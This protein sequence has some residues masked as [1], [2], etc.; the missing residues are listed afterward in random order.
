M[1]T[2]E[3]LHAGDPENRALWERFMPHCLEALTAVYERLGVRFDVQLGESFYDPMLA[4]IISWA[5][6]RAE[7]ASALANAVARAKI[8]GL[9]TNRDLL[10]RV[11]R[12]PAFLAGHTDTAFLERHKVD[13]PLVEDETLFALAAALADAASN[14]ASA[15]L[16]G[17]LPSGWRNLPSQPQRKQ[18]SA[19]S[20]IHDVEYRLTRDGLVYER[21]DVALLDAS[22]HTVVLDVAGVQRRFA[23]AA[24][25]G[26]VCVDSSLGAVTLRPVD[27]FP[28]PAAQV[29]AGSLLAPMPGTVVRVAVA[30][31]DPVGAGQPLLWLE[32]MKMEHTIAA[33]SAGVVTELP[34]GVGNQV[35][36]GA[37]LAIVQPSDASDGR[38]LHDPEKEQE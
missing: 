14:R 20:G 3:R 34:V 7:A 38:K 19:T 5:P 4:K 37:V 18:Y 8:H 15:Q 23:V 16:L 29:A 1:I 33:P 6:S 35:Q 24:Y 36:I 11:L 12:H 25:P 22:E 28:D 21:Q 32:A 9:R 2:A 31:G 30:A 26:L 17:D 27:R 13:E 10:V